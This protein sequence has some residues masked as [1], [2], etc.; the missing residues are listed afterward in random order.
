MEDE[1]RKLHIPI[2]NRHGDQFKLASEASAFRSAMAKPQLD[3][4]QSGPQSSFSQ[5]MIQGEVQKKEERKPMQFHIELNLDDN[6]HPEKPVE[7]NDMQGGQDSINQDDDD[8]DDDDDLFGDN[9]EKS[10]PTNRDDGKMLDKRGEVDNHDDDDLFVGN[11]NSL[12]RR[13]A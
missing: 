11:D 4:K 13:K 6:E 9:S 2:P 10:G 8:D 1:D 5:S 12:G 7:N 3:S